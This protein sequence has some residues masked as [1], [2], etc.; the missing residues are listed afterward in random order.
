MTAPFSRDVT[1]E[2]WISAANA[3]PERGGPLTLIRAMHLAYGES[4]ETM[5]GEEIAGRRYEPGRSFSAKEEAEFFLRKAQNFSQG[6]RGTQT[7][8]IQAFYNGSAEPSTSFHVTARGKGMAHGETEEPNERGTKAQGMRLTEQIVQGTFRERERILS[9]HENLANRLASENDELRSRALDAERLALELIRKEAINL[10]EQRMTELR[11]ERGTQ[12][13]QKIMTFLP[14]ILRQV[15]G[16]KDII[17]ESMAD[18]A[19]LES[20]VLHMRKMPQRSK[21][22]SHDGDRRGLARA[23]AGL[24]PPPRADRIEARSR[25]RGREGPGQGARGRRAGRGQGRST[26]APRDERS[27]GAQARGGVT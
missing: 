16:D 25:R 17:P 24:G 2:E 8:K 21:T 9:A 23:R 7:F 18:T 22:R 11:F 27:F 12:L 20:V 15:T 6:L 4:G 3:D 1:L 13:Q 14:A 5:L 10:H 26:R 19:I